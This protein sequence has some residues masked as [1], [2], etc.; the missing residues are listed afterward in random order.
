MSSIQRKPHP[1]E[2]APRVRRG[3]DLKIIFLGEASVGM[4]IQKSNYT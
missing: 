4:F 3:A 1:E 2:R